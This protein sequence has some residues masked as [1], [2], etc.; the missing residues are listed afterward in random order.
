M[1][2][3]STVLLNGEIR[4]QHLYAYFEGLGLKTHGAENFILQ[5]LKL[6]AW[7]HKAPG[8]FNLGSRQKK[9]TQFELSQEIESS[10]S[11]S[12]S[13]YCWFVQLMD[14]YNQGNHGFSW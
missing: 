7:K 5:L 14:Y 4:Q 13:Y 2:V 6:A 11:I 1:Y 10:N 9:E 12:T 3:E 8:V